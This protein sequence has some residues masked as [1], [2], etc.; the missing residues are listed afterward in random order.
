MS[1][2]KLVLATTVDGN[3]YTADITPSGAGNITIDVAA[4]AA[5]DGAGNDNTAATQVVTLFDN[6]PP[7]VAIQNAPAIVN[8]TTPYNVT[9]EFSED[10]SGF[11]IGDI[12][13]GNGT[14]SNF[15]AVDGNTYTADITPTGAGDI[16]ID[17]AAGVAQD[18]ANNDNTAAA[19]VVTVFDNTAPTVPTVNSLTTHDVTPVITGTATLAAGETLTV[20]VAGATYTVVP[21]GSGNWSLDTGT[22]VATSGTFAPNTGGTNG[23]T[24]NEVVATATDGA[25]NSS[26]DTTN[27]E[28][29]IDVDADDDGIPDAVE[30]A[31]APDPDAD[32]IPN[33]LDLDSDGDGIPDAIENGASGV[34]T[35]GDGIDD[36]YDVD[37]TGGTDA[38]GDGVDDNV[39]PRDTDNDS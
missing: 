18:G 13:V 34:D 8:S 10:V 6:V 39:I 7:T 30:N 15:V 20:E 23:L 16:T 22:A 32:T 19:Q 2:E 25:G 24:A 31:A 38:N 27:N 1:A 35:D 33:N 14:A 3:T 37:Q 17:V 12:T 11:A 28:L 29:T 4:A 5:Q 9:F 36:T 26:T 21:D